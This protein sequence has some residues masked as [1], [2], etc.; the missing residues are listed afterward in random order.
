MYNN[1]SMGSVSG[2][3]YSGLQGNNVWY[4][5]I[6][7]GL[8]SKDQYWGISLADTVKYKKPSFYLVCTSIMLRSTAII[9]LPDE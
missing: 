1:G 9:K 2:N 3:I 4:P 6:E 5:S 7:T 8:S